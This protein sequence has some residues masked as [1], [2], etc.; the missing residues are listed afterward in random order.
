MASHG[1]SPRCFD[2]FHRAWSVMGRQPPKSVSFAWFEEVISG[3]GE[4]TM[5]NPWDFPMYLPLIYLIYIHSY[6][7]LLV[8]SAYN[9]IYRMYNPIYNQL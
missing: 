5:G 7:H 3:M 6:G 9:P 1:K 4:K 2:V 8:I